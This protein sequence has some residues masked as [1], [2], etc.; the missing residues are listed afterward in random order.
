MNLDRAEAHRD[1]LHDLDA[2]FTAAEEREINAMTIELATKA[3]DR[4]DKERLL[5]MWLVAHADDYRDA[6]IDALGLI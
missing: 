2:G 5:P 6:A 1:Q 4:M 3:F